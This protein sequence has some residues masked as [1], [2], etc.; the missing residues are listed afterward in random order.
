MVLPLRVDT[1]RLTLLRPST[2]DAGEIFE[3]YAS[4]PDVTRYLGWPRHENLDDTRGFL[5]FS[6]AQWRREGAGPYLIRSRD[7][8]RLLG[9]TGVAKNDE[10]EAMAGYVLARDAWGRGLATEALT[11][12]VE[13]ARAI[14]LPRLHALCHPDHRASWRVLEKCGFQRNATWTRKMEF[15]NLARG[16][17]QD[18]LCFA[19]VP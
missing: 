18:V 14:R 15:P 2:A 12:I 19:R 9:S 1:E 6:A 5:T 13:A 3:R 10:V 4:D 8:G 7:D 11:A 16:V 17:D